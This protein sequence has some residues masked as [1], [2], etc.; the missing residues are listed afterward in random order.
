MKARIQACV[1]NGQRVPQKG[2]AQ[3]IEHA[4]GARRV[5]AEHAD[6][7]DRIRLRINQ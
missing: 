4:V 2:G 1:V 7:T 6:Q 3:L 5:R